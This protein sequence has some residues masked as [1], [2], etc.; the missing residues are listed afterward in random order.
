MSAL[1]ELDPFYCEECVPRGCECNNRYV[2]EEENPDNPPSELSEFN[3]WKWIIPGKVWCYI[4]E[5]GREYPCCE[6]DYEKE[7]WDKRVE[8]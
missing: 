7:G 6:F 3:K 8:E 4:D 2:K 5:E 1:R